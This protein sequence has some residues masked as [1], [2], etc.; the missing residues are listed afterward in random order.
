MQR[1]WTVEMGGGC[2]HP[3]RVGCIFWGFP[4]VETMGF[5]PSPLQGP[6]GRARV[7]RSEEEEVVL[8]GGG[9]GRC[10]GWGVR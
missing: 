10:L 5:V 7:Q 8:G 6:G 2:R 9:V 3:G 1:L 4:M